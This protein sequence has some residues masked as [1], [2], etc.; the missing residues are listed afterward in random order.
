MTIYRDT[1]FA[2]TFRI[3]AGVPETPVN[4]TGAAFTAWIRQNIEDPDP[5]LLM[6]STTTF[7]L[8]ITDAINGRL[9]LKLTKAQTHSLPLGLVVA[10]FMRT[11]LADT[12]QRYFGAVFEVKE[13]VT[14]LP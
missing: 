1:V 8:T 10:D 14:R 2:Q 6:L 7:G 11:D 13:A 5:P 3:L 12:P 4:L 9:Q